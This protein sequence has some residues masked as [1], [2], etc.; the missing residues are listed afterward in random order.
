MADI[1]VKITNINQIRAAF[2]AAPAKMTV[3]LNTAIKKSIFVIQAESM[4][5]TPVKTGRLRASTR[6]LFAPL[7]G[8]VGTHVAYDVFVHWGTKY[9][10][11]RPFLLNAVNTEQ[12]Q[13]DTFFREAVQNT[14]DSIA[15]ETG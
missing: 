7:R 9:M 11:A 14:L 13:V 8:E 4:K 3:A 5:N 10:K 12:G 6:S 1:Q 15:H 2:L